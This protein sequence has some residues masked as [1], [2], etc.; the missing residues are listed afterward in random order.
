V[1][2]VLARAL[3]RAA[4]IAGGRERLAVHLGVEP[5]DLELWIDGAELTPQHIFLKAVD[6]IFEYHFPKH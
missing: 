2:S 6:L 1:P 5:S 3:K 4:E